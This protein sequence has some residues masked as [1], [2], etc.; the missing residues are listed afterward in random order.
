MSHQP[1]S[2]SRCRKIPSTRARRRPARAP[3]AGG[4]R[5]RSPRRGRPCAPGATRPGR[6][7]QDLGAQGVVVV[8]LL[9]EAD[10]GVSPEPVPLGGGPVEAVDRDAQHGLPGRSQVRRRA[11]RRTSSCRPVDAVD[12]DQ[13]RARPR[14]PRGGQ[15][16]RQVGAATRRATVGMAGPSAMGVPHE[17]RARHISRRRGIFPRP[18]PSTGAFRPYRGRRAP[19][20][21]GPR[22]GGPVRV[23][24]T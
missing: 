8:G 19:V 18:L 17:R 23:P 6:A 20:M 7:V 9:E 13:D 4:A 10:G 3:P 16:E 14:L 21:R 2:S 22:P 24:G 12:A 1:A 11:R 5:C 15:R